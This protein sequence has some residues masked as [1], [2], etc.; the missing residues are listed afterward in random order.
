MPV[1]K[2]RLMSSAMLLSLLGLAGAAVY[3]ALH[4]IYQVDEAQNLFMTH[5]LATGQGGRYFTNALLW[6]LG[7]MSWL[8]RS[9]HD[10]VGIFTASRL[11]FVGVF[12][13]NIFLLALNTGRKLNSVAGLAALFGAAT[14]APLWDYGFEIRHDNL[15]LTG[16]LLMWWLGRVA[17]RG[18]ASYVGLGILT[19]VIPFLSLKAVAYAL[20][21]S[22]ALLACPPPLHGRSRAALA[23]AWLAGACAAA[24]A[25]A[26]AYLLS[27]A[28]AVFWDG[29][30]AGMQS[31]AVAKGF[32][33]DVALKRLPA[34]VPLLRELVVLALGALLV[35]LCRHGRAALRWDSLVPEAALLLGSYALLLLNPTPFPYN[36]VN[37]VPF[38][39]LLAFPFALQLVAFD[40]KVRHM[41][42][43]I[44]AILLLAHVIPFVHATA[45]H[46]DFTN[47][48]QQTLMRTAEAMTDPEQDRVYDAIGM[49]PTRAS[50]GY[51]WYLHSLN[52]A[53]FASGKFEPVSA[54]L[55]RH[56]PAVLI[57]SYRTDM[58]PPAEWQFIAQRYVPLADDFWLL[59][60]VLAPGGG[61]YEVLHGGRYLLVQYDQ[62]KFLPLRHASLAGRPAASTPIALA[63]GTVRVES[64]ADVRPALLWIGPNLASL[65]AIGEGKYRRLFQNFY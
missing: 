23:T 50:I 65:P 58:L 17:P 5:A 2:V 12:F 45:R 19:V 36:L 30:R 48:R 57:R 3:L 61:N 34:Q 41:G 44:G 13:L 24:L 33:A 63:P 54:M 4:R 59:G 10:A 37:L 60:R 26:A 64:P 39:Y 22:V 6:M 32:S 42:T 51:Q 7:P 40:W 9:L 49:V 21:L 56:P 8:V 62:G 25:I 20:P 31:G 55:A 38:A 18:R 52:S 53:A 43:V 1:N 28:A 47:A 15:I 27:G 16:V 11:L 14:L 35:Q 29:L 46:V